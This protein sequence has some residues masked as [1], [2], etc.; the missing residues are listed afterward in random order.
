MTM[1]GA[2]VNP[3]VS[4]EAV[5]EAVPIPAPTGPK[6]LTVEERLEIENIYLK[7]E[8]LVL[9]SER[10]RADIQ[11]SVEMRTEQQNKMRELQARL[12]T[13]YGCDM[14]KVKILPDGTIL[15]SAQ[16]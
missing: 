7:V 2:A 16:G 15:E 6:K 4:A 12:S 1:N 14:T 11:K 9:Q 5:P 13:K 10:L 3:D 8:N